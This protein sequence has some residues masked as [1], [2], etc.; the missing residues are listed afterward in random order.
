MHSQI[1][2]QYCASQIKGPGEKIEKSRYLPN[3]TFPSWSHIDPYFHVNS[4]FYLHYFI[5]HRFEG[6]RKELGMDLQAFQKLPFGTF[7]SGFQLTLSGHYERTKS[8]SFNPSLSH[9]AKQNALC[10]PK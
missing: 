10:Q 8:F 1:S 5:D 6:L 7:L 3:R 2:R 9:S 4:E